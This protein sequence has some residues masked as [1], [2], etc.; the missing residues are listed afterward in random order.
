MKDQENILVI[1]AGLAG[2]ITAT[3]LKENNKSFDWISPNSNNFTNEKE[4]KNFINE[5]S[6]SYSPKL[7][8][9]DYLLDQIKADQLFGK[10]ECHNFK[11]S[12]SVRF[13]GLG[14][15]WGANLAKKYILKKI[16]SDKFDFESAIEF[17]NNFLPSVS[18]SKLIVNKNFNKFQE[19]FVDQISNF[20]N[21][22][23]KNFIS[24]PSDLC[25]NNPHGIK[26]SLLDHNEYVFGNFRDECQ[27]FNL[28]KKIKKGVVE[29]IK[30]I[31][32]DSSIVSFTNPINGAKKSKTYSKIF[33]C[34]GAIESFRIANDALFK[35]NQKFTTYY[36]CKL[37]HHPIAT[38][39]CF[40]KRSKY[41]SG[42]VASSMIDVAYKDCCYINF[43]PLMP[44][45]RWKLQKS[46]ILKKIIFNKFITPLISKFWVT[47]LYFD[48]KMSDSYIQYFKTDNDSKSNV[49][50]FGSYHP[51]HNSFMKKT[52]KSIS[53]EFRKLGIF[54]FLPRI[55]PPGTDQHI[56]G[57][58]NSICHESSG[59]IFSKKIKT[60][61]YAIDASS[62]KDMNISNPTFH[63]L[64][65]TIK[66]LEYI[67][68]Q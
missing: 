1:G 14:N 54:I 61:I 22:N 46:K 35:I 44:L 41:D 32:D 4:L 26:K 51:S 57:S 53:N 7:S 11:L 30:I 8:R 12:R 27:D 66:K 47:N 36:S 3:W 17:V 33:L 43:V 55:L 37:N 52:I 31:S 13:G 68:E 5:S 29:E 20:I 6:F 21:N 25:L 65:K 24:Y 56:G 34:A 40:V 58:L 10:V 15:Y 59:N 19:N 64:L 42:L 67:F 2:L 18:S 9:N 60:N 39:F 45:L 49:K 62:E 63:F 16:S 48:S 28:R 50:V 23:S 38:S